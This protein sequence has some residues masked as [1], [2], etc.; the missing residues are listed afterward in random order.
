MSY[1]QAQR[2]RKDSVG[3]PWDFRNEHGWLWRQPGITASEPFSVTEITRSI[4]AIDGVFLQVI[5]QLRV[6]YPSPPLTG[7]ANVQQFKAVYAL[8]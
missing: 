5:Q 1:A 2:R 7:R 8:A 6:Y 4:A 3:T